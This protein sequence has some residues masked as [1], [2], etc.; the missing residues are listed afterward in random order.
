VRVTRIDNPGEY[1]G[2]HA[3]GLGQPVLADTQRLE[4]L[5]LEQ[6]TGGD[7]E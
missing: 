5:L 6:F 3:N 2:R 1:P 7:K 4:E